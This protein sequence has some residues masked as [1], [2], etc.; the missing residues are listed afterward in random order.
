MWLVAVQIQP[1]SAHVR[2]E[3]ERELT[4]FLL[5]HFQVEAMKIGAK[6]MKRAYKD[7]KLD[8]IDVC[9]SNNYFVRMLNINW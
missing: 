2:S 4:E 5:P 7:V 1:H 8:Q 3:G 6:E 9:W